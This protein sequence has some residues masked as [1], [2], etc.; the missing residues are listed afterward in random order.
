[1]IMQ[2]Q[3]IIIRIVFNEKAFRLFPRRR[4]GVPDRAIQDYGMISSVYFKRSA[5]VCALAA[6]FPLAAQA[7]DTLIVT[8]KPDDSASAQT[9]GYSAKTSTGA[10]KTDQPLIT[11]AQSVSVITRQQIADQGANT[12]SQALQYTP[13]VYSS[14]GGGATR[15]DTISLRGYHGGDVDNLFLDGM[16]LMSDG[17]SHNVL[18]I[19]P[20]FIERVDVIRGPSS[21]LYGQSVPGGVVNLT[22]KR[23]QFSQQGHFRLTGGTQ[24]TK[25]AA[26][27]Y[28]DAINDQ[29]AWRLIG[30]TRSSDTQYDHTR[31]ERYAISP[32]LLWQPDSD[33]S[34]LLRAYLQK[35]PSGGYHGS[36]P[37][38]GTRYAHNGRKLSP[39]T[40]EG[41]PGD[42]YQR[43]EQIYSYEFNHQFN[44]VWSA[45]SAG[46]Y[47]H[48]NVSL[49][50][51]YQ[52]GWVG[53]SDMLSRGYSGSRG[54]LDAWSTDN[55]LRAD[56]TT[57]EL[58][59]TLILGAEYHRFR[60]DLW[61]GAGNAAPLNPFTGYTPQT[62]HTITY[63]DNNNRRYYQTGFYLQDEMVWNRW[64]LDVSGR[65]DRIVSQQVSDTSGTSNRRSDDHISG[66]ASLLYALDNGLS[67]YLSYSQA[68][69]PAMLPGADGTLLK[70]TTAEQVEAGLK[71]QPPG[72]SDLYSIAIYDLMQKDVA[73]RDPNIA[74]ATYIPAGKVHSQ[75]VELEAHNQITPQLS[76]IASYTWNRLRFQDT[77]DGTDSNT[78]Q[79]SPD[80][81]ASFW[82]R[83][84]LPAGITVGAGVRY[85]G[86]QW[87][88]DANTE[89]LPSVTL[90]DAMARADLGAWS[91]A[92]KGAY[93]QVNAN[94]IG[95]REYLSGCYGTGNCYWGAERSVTATVGYDF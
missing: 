15:F 47:T 28:T 14:F 12:V 85:I 91:T 32:S 90:I 44:D 22:S 77:K 65:Y 64:H 1:M 62:G 72:S 58:A 68:I 51:V 49:D 76:T 40:N 67:P 30:M 87:A 66:R 57:G 53:D 54:S 63:S 21:A 92:M 9:Q 3:T 8:A 25:G 69:T 20:W 5:L 89:R 93:I 48:T 39:S 61:T 16:R 45:Y 4:T 73:T 52:V 13:G 6:A 56:F 78:P 70:P 81:M 26:F 31:E 82:A 19:D 86:K 24:N 42:G 33:T 95:D 37:L 34:L 29:W 50:Q 74:T 94:N 88:D 23:P 43:R 75:G 11:T 27:D 60:N 83:Y 84:Q 17:G 36:L 79:L 2:K 35:D 71:F 10:T 38:D 7:E 55:R 59:H 46:S 80:Q 18:Q 41:D